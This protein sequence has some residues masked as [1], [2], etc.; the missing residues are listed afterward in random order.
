MM[1]NVRMILA[2]ASPQRRTLLEGLSLKFEVI[3]SDIDEDAHPERD[4]LKRSKI[5]ARL[6]AEDIARKH[7]EAV[8][9]GCDTLVVASSG[10]LLEKPLDADDARRMLLLQSGRTS[11]VH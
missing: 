2:S 11:E 5:L 6:K 3:P 7:S 4:P 1:Q 9:I 10:T 8:V